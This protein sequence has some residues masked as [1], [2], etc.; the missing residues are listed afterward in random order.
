MDIRKVINWRENKSQKTE[1]QSVN[2]KDRE[3]DANTMV[4]RKA[5]YYKKLRLK[6]L[7]CHKEEL[8]SY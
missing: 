8:R 6:W 2:W 7:V 1:G 4:G 5:F 3:T